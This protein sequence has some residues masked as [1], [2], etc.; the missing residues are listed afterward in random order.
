MGNGSYQGSK[1]APSLSKLA[2][3][4]QNKQLPNIVTK[5]PKKTTPFIEFT[6]GKHRVTAMSPS[7]GR[8][9]RYRFVIFRL[10]GLSK[11]R[12]SK[13]SAERQMTVAAREME[14]VHL[15]LSMNLARSIFSGVGLSSGGGGTALSVGFCTMKTT[16]TPRISVA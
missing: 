5:I 2:Y 6:I 11:E 3:H 7:L 14:V 9:L 15:A 4:S 1:M 8:S 13:A 12:L 10:P 16:P